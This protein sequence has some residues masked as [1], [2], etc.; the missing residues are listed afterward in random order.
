MIRIFLLLLVLLYTLDA[1]EVHYNLVI[2]YKTVNYTGVDVEAMTINDGIPGPTIEATEGDWVTIEVHNKMD[3]STSIHWHGILFPNHHNQDGVPYLTTKPIKAH[4]THTFRYPLLQSGTYWY[5]SH[6]GL[7]EQRGVYGS[8]MIHPKKQTHKVDKEFVVVLSDWT[9]EDPEE[10]MRTLKRGSEYYA[11]KKGSVQSLSGAIKNGGVSNMLTQW[12]NQMPGM[13]ISDVYYDA[14]FINEKQTSS[15]KAQAG[16]K[17]RL[18]IINASA[19]TYFYLQ[20]AK[21]PLQIISSDGIDVE[22]FYHD[23]VL[24]AVAETY[25][26]IITVPKNGAYKLRATAQ[27]GSG[28]AS[29]FIGS[30]KKVAV[31]DIPKPNLYGMKCGASMKPSKGG[32]KCGGSMKCCSGK[33]NMDKST[34]PMP[35]YP[36]LK[37]LEKITLPKEKKW[38]EVHLKLVGDMRSYIWSFNG[39]TIS[40][41][42][43]IHIKKGENIRFIFENETMM[44]HPLHLHGHFFRVLNGQGDFSPL[45][46]TI[47]IQ[48]LATST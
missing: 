16:E 27:D 23:K 10:V 18:R 40:E 12:W 1:K 38:R 47:D 7:Q 9:N 29:L 46:H 37:A 8:I 5:H 36:K 45:K 44:H 6:T 41:E 3:V 34:R 31:A 28:Q 42:D 21:N 20:N 15:L 2:D 39:K 35:P 4:S 22:P 24:I 48:P 17:I 14:F 11:I 33:M 19:S 43:K 13:D 30:G 32:M 26:A 25:D